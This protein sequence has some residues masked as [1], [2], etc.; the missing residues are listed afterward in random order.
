[1]L[2]H[3]HQ[4]MKR[5]GLISKDMERKITK[6]NILYKM[7]Y[8]GLIVTNYLKFFITCKNFL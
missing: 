6:L 8:A 4:D 2:K 1:M 7:K 5:K 3:I